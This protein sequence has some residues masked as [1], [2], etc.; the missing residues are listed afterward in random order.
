[1]LISIRIFPYIAKPLFILK[2]IIMYLIHFIKIV[3]NVINALYLRP[4]INTVFDKVGKFFDI[5]IAIIVYTIPGIIKKVYTFLKT[6]P[7]EICRFIWII[8]KGK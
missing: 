1:L 6:K 3:L 7:R 4:I 8:L 5:V 2:K